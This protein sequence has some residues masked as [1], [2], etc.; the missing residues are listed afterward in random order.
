MQAIR[1][2]AILV[3]M[4]LLVA[5][6]RIGPS[7]EAPGTPSVEPAAAAGNPLPAMRWAAP[8]PARDGQ[9]PESEC[10]EG[11]DETIIMEAG[12]DRTL[13]AELQHYPTDPEWPRAPRS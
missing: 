2:A 11:Q 8:P 6:V 12:R 4:I 10:E 3:I 1:D 7:T 9:A 13:Q 5:S